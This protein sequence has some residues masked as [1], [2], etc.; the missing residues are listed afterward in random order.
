MNARLTVLAVAAIGV[1]V[2]SGCTPASSGGG[3]SAT[4]C[5][6]S[7]VAFLQPAGCR[8][9]QSGPQQ[10]KPVSDT[11]PGCDSSGWGPLSGCSGGDKNSSGDTFGPDPGVD[12]NLVRNAARHEGG[13]IEVATEF[14]WEVQSA[15]IDGRGD[16]RT[17]VIIPCGCVAQR[18]ALAK[19][20]AIASPTTDVSDADQ[21]IADQALNTLPLDQQADVE[22]QGR[23]LAR[24]IVAQ[25][26]SQI[27]QDAA[28]L[29]RTGR[30]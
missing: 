27:D 20:G 30:L 23:A 26:S 18:V 7:G 21:S 8:G 4:G 11:T 25:R 6:P 22:D 13:H 2:L 1:G 15:T 24:K 16:G 14:G 3:S 29:L 5:D 9:G 10:A 19:A 17:V 28:Q 12:P